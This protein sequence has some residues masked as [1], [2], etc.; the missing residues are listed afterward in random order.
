M[1][2]VDM[3]NVVVDLFYCLSWNTNS[4]VTGKSACLIWKYYK[5]NAVVTCDSHQFFCKKATFLELLGYRHSSRPDYNAKMTLLF[6]LCT[7]VNTRRF[8][9]LVR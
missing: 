3:M 5:G 1:D 8:N 6:H 9:V 2:F 7:S 4:A